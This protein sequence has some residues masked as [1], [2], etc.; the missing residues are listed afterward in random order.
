MSGSGT[1]RDERA[2]IS[3]SLS[4][5][6]D[7]QTMSAIARLRSAWSSGDAFTSKWTIR[8]FATRLWIIDFA[9]RST[10][11]LPAPV[12]PTIAAAHCLESDTDNTSVLG[13][14]FLVPGPSLVLG[15]WCWSSDVLSSWFLINVTCQVPRTRHDQGPGTDQGL[16]TEDQGPVCVQRIRSPTPRCV[17]G[18]LPAR[19]G[20]LCTRAQYTRSPNRIATISP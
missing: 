10:V 1:R 9:R 4:G 5:V 13:P 8:E 15:S 12:P 2:S 7:A 11:V 14:R 17:T 20:F 6:E 18:G 3:V 16:W 19:T